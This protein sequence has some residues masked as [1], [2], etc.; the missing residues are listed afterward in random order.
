MKTASYRPDFQEFLMSPLI[1]RLGRAFISKHVVEP[2]KHPAEFLSGAFEGLKENDML[3]WESL[4]SSAECL[5]K[6]A[7]CLR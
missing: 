2:L 1:K 7:P 4:E 6:S 5:K 3:R